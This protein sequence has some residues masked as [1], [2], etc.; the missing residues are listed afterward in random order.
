MKHLAV[1]AT[2][3]IGLTLGACTTISNHPTNL[4]NPAKPKPSSTYAKKVVATTVARPSS[5]LAGE[6]DKVIAGVNRLRAEKGLPPLIPNRT[7]MAY[8]QLRASEL[9]TLFS[10]NRPNGQSYSAALT[11]GYTGENIAAG[12]NTAQGT[13]LQWQASKMHYQN[14]TSPNYQTIGV[15]AVY[16]PNT[17]FGYYWVQV[18]GDNKTIAPFLFE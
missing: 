9:P 6:I 7:L 15:G 12:R 1:L 14:M 13:L 5:E 3:I 4:T 18:F 8:A 10:H 16:A 17:P 11:K 2:G